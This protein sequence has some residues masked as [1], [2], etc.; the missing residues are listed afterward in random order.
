MKLTKYEQETIV[1]Y[2]NGDKLATIYTADP[3]IMNRLDK[4]VEKHPDT[5]KV[6]ETTEI[7]KTYECPKKLVSFRHPVVL[8]EEQKAKC[9]ERLAKINK[10]K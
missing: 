2:N 3:V 6:I 4:M 9:R 8:S 5:Y 1:N 10:R 7:S